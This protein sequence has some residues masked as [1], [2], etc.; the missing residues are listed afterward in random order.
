VDA[1]GVDRAAATRLPVVGFGIG[2]TAERLEAIPDALVLD[3][4][5]EAAAINRTLL[6]FAGQSEERTV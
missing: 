5:A 3:P 6:V 4:A 2:A 1:P